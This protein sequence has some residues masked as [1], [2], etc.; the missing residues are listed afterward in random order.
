MLVQVVLIHVLVLVYDGMSLVIVSRTI[1]GLVAAVTGRNSLYPCAAD[2]LVR[3][4]F[5]LVTHESTCTGRGVEYRAR[6]H[7]G[8]MGD[9]A[10]GG[11]RNMG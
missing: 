11:G 5:G 3:P 6:R 10:A 8:N 2:I 9:S 7:S 4:Y 1:F